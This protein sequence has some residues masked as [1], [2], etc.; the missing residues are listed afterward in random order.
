AAKMG[1][2]LRINVASGL[3]LG[4]LLE[5][6]PFLLLEVH[7]GRGYVFFEMFERGGTRDRQNYRRAM[8]QPGDGEL[9]DCRMMLTGHAFESSAAFGE[10]ARSNGKPGNETQIVPFTKRQ[11]RFCF[12]A[13]IGEIVLVLNTDDMRRLLRALDFFLIYFGKSDM[14]Y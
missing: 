3:R 1:H 11:G 13:S 14:P 6:F 2:V 10:F 4:R 7:A 12:G 5:G 8:Q 9:S